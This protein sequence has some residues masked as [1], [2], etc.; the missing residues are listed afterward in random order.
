LTW[1]LNSLY[2]LCNIVDLALKI[3]PLFWNLR[4]R[5]V[6]HQLFRLRVSMFVK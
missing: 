6:K 2:L 1:T 3:H 4:L 5:T